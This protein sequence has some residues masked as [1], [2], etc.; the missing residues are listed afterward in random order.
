MRIF[1]K[2]VAAVTGLFAVVTGVWALADADGFAD[3]A[4]FP[5]GAHFVHDIGAFQVG[6]GVSL[7][8]ALLWTD[9]LAVV[10]AGFAV[11][12]TVHVYNHLADSDLGG[13][14]W[15]PYALAVASVLAVAAL[16]VR[17]RQLGWVVGDPGDAAS[18]DLAPFARQK[19]VLL[20]TYRRDGTPV[21]APVSIVVAGDHAYL[22]SFEKAWKTR[23]LA[24]NPDAIITP[25][26]MR[27]RPTGPG[28]PATVRRVEGAQA[29]AA[30]HALARKYPVLHGV[31]VPTMHRL[32]RAKTG[33]TVHFVLT[34]LTP[35]TPA[36]S[37]ASSSSSATARQSP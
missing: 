16:I 12:N 31:L 28:L 6:I 18:P 24:R 29:Q 35:A 30:R 2:L 20:T 33:R 7:L 17:L 34:P 26:T 23:R 13:A 10:L 37:V 4:Q 11:G 1:V 36:A 27:G 9:A 32:G 5:P 14:G 21:G 8:L 15:T 19:T 22:R 3:W 25:S